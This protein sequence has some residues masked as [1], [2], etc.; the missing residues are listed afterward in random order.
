MS[1]IIDKDLK[2]EKLKLIKD[3]KMAKT[4]MEFKMK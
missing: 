1:V 4:L 3:F 2:A